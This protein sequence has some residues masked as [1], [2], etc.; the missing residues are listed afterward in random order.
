MSALVERDLEDKIV[1]LLRERLTGV[2]VESSWGHSPEGEV[3]GEDSPEDS[4]V[5]AVAVG[6]PAW[7]AYLEPCCSIPVALAI[8]VRR[9]TA[10]DAA[11]LAEVAEP[12]ANLLLALQMDVES[13]GPLSSENFSADGVRVEGGSAPTFSASA[14]VWH[15]SR[16]FTV[17]GVIVQ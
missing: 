15:I 12:I 16:A 7:D 1:A 8:T 4:V 3:K 6:A 2:R 10:P 14:N 13:V 11:R 5:V 17:R 9:E